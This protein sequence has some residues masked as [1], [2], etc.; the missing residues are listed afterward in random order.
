MRYRRSPPGSIHLKRENRIFLVGFAESRH[1]RIVVFSKEQPVEQVEKIEENPVLEEKRQE[2]SSS[3]DP[4]MQDNEEASVARVRK[5]PPD[6]TVEEL[7]RHKV[8]HVVF[9]SCCR[10]SHSGY[11]QVHWRERGLKYVDRVES[12]FLLS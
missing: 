10:H 9:R 1:H 3:A 5:L 12:V 7:D 4:V 2:A 6:P 8:T 11:K